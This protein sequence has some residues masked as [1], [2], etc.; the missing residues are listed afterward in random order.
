MKCL[1]SYHCCL[2]LSSSH[3]YYN[4]VNV[5][6]HEL[7]NPI[8]GENQKKIKCYTGKCFYYARSDVLTALLMKS[9]VFWKMIL[10][11][12]VHI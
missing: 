2:Y 8:F 6:K 10:H 7:Y 1:R 5:S 3:K 12:I 11:T 9:L 4:E